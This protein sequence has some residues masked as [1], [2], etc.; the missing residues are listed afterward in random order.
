MGEALRRVDVAGAG[1]PDG[2]SPFPG[3]HPFEV[4]MHRVFLADAPK[5]LASLLRSPARVATGGGPVG[6]RQVVAGPRRAAAGDGRRTRWTLPPLVPGTDPVAALAHELAVAGRL[7]GL[8]WRRRQVRDQ[9]AH[10]DGQCQ[11]APRSAWECLGPVSR[12]RL[13]RVGSLTQAEAA[14]RGQAGLMLAL[15]WNR[16]PGSYSALIPASRSYLAGP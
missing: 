4:D 3:L 2:R 5:A 11:F 16:L 8:H 13:G 6:V 14:G 15:R 9:L 7:L 1:W 12:L 10:D